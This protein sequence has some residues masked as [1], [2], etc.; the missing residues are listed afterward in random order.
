MEIYVLIGMG[1]AGKNTVAPRPG[2]RHLAKYVRGYTVRYGHAYI[3]IYIY[4][5][6]HLTL[7]QLFFT[8]VEYIGSDSTAQDA[9]N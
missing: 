4:T 3:Y 6:G 8:L 7:Q 9:S 2:S 1:C 5:K